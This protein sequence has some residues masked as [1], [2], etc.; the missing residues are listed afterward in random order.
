MTPSEKINALS[1]ELSRRIDAARSAQAALADEQR[2]QGRAVSQEL[3]SREEV[4]AERIAARAETREI[5]RAVIADTRYR[6]GDPT[7][8]PDAQHRALLELFGEA[9]TTRSNVVPM[10]RAIEAAGRK[11]RNEI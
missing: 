8:K 4:E 10:A 6:L 1:F 3:F 7:F 2:R 5:I 11:R 9:S